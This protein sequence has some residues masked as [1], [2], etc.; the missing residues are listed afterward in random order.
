MSQML[1]ALFTMRTA[2]SEWKHDCVIYMPAGSV[3]K[4]EMLSVIAHYK[5]KIM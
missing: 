4:Y 1:I 2:I 5:K 3:N